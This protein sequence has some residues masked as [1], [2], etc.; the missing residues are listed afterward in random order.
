M[1]QITVE[2]ILIERDAD[3][4]MMELEGEIQ[5]KEN[6]RSKRRKKTDCNK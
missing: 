5:R 1:I 3:F 6:E 2:R 4:N